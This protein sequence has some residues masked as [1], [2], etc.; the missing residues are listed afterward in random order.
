MVEREGGD[1]GEDGMVGYREEREE[2]SLVSFVDEEASGEGEEGECWE[3]LW[4]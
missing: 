3:G 4:R 2:E 1:E